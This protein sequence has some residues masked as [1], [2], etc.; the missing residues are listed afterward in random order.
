[1][2]HAIQK[3]ISIAW[4][5]PFCFGKWD[6]AR[7]TLFGLRSLCRALMISCKWRSPS[8]IC[9]GIATWQINRRQFFGFD[10]FSSVITSP[11]D[12][13]WYYCIISRYGFSCVLIPKRWGRHWWQN[14][15]IKLASL[16]FLSQRIVLGKNSLTATEIPWYIWYL[17]H[18]N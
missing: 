7:S 5:I 16:L 3:S 6:V 17:G 4:T 1:M 18:Y 12:N 2:L 10:A 14:V 13:A 8:N 15:D 9:V 11:F